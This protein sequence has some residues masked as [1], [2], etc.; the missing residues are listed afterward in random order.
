MCVDVT[1]TLDDMAGAVGGDDRVEYLMVFMLMGTLRLHD[2]GTV[3]GL[4]ED[5]LRDLLCLVGD[6]KERLTLEITIEGVQG[7][8]RYI[9]EH[10]GLQCLVPAEK[11]TGRTQDEDIKAQDQ[12]PGLHAPLLAEVDRDEIR[13]AGRRIHT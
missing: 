2:R 5:H 6:D 3:M 4:I 13:T 10:D 1:D 12:V 11:D 7:L 8:G 9:L